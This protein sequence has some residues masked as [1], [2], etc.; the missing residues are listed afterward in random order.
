MEIPQGVWRTIP[1]IQVCGLNSKSVRTLY[2]LIVM[3]RELFLNYIN[4]DFV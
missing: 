4:Y 2:M 1:C 3:I